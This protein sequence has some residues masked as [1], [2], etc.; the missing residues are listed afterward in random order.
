MIIICIFGGI[1]NQ[2]FQYA[3]GKA[4]AYYHNTELQL[5]IY[6]P[7]DYARFSN[8]TYREYCLNHFNINDKL[9]EERTIN[10]YLTKRNSRV[11]RKLR[12]IYESTKPLNKRRYIDDTSSLLRENFFNL[13][14]DLYIIGY[15]G[16]EFYFSNIQDIIRQEFQ[17]KNSPNRIN[18]EYIDRLSTCN[19]VSVHIRRGDYLKPENIALLGIL[20]KQYY[21]DAMRLLESKI[22]NPNYFVFSD[23][24]DWAEK[25]IF[26]NFPVTIVKHNLGKN[27]VEDLR[28]MSNCKHHII[29]NS[30][31]SWWGAWLSNYPKKIVIAPVKKSNLSNQKNTRYPDDWL[32]LSY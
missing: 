31:F 3:A 1:G 28:L 23:D 12:L 24:P 17:L 32:L 10:R 26:S 22:P 16:S 27:D 14:N 15:F 11:I 18:Q 2:M 7:D 4:L 6:T 13:S 9:A 21:I 20:P 5:D 8:L 25:N 19:S 30:T 29:A